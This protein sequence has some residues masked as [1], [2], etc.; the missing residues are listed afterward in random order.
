MFIFVLVV[1]GA[2]VVYVMSPE[3]RRRIVKRVMPVLHAATD[4]ARHAHVQSGPFHDAMRARTRWTVL[5]PAIVLV[6]V[7]I[8]FRMVLVDG[9][10]ASP[11]TLIAW[12]GS[13]GLRTT[14]GEW[15]RLVTSIFIHAGFIQLVCELAGFV[16][17]GMLLERLVGPVAFLSV[18]VGSGI[19]ASV[20]SL[21]ADPMAV[22][23]GSSGAIFGLYGLLLAYAACSFFQQ[24]TVKIPVTAAKP[25]APG[26]AIFLLYSTATGDLSGGR[27]LHGLVMGVVC[28]VPL[29]VGV[30]SRKPPL[31]RTAAAMTAALAIAIV[32]A[33]PLRGFT[34]VRPAIA[35]VVAFEVKTATAYDKSVEQFKLGVMNADALAQ[36]IDR[37]I[38]PELHAIRL[39]LKSLDRVPTQ[40]K[41]I[42]ASADEYLRL[43]DESWRLRAE[44]L[45]TR[46][47]LTLR[48]ADR[49]EG[50]SLDIFETIKPS[51][52]Q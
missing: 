32:S 33:I 8:F 47:M 21:S 38:L 36:I 20:A 43:R 11:E 42:V 35:Q 24:S 19:F 9:P 27:A 14:N 29:T 41:S 31:V 1:I 23:V 5:T 30:G 51:D 25:L 18:Y 4:V 7:V 28:G 26:V 3:E 17:V 46:N 10:L 12:G 13:S 50:A 37:T 44:G 16:M 40:D 22:S 52:E 15:W 2:F 48:K 49:T 45:H 39:H 6:S 34:D